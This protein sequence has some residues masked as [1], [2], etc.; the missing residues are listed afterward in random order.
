MTT[1]SN[2]LLLSAFAIAISMAPSGFGQSDVEV[3]HTKVAMR[4]IGHELL[5]STGDS[6]SR[7]LPVEEEPD[8][9]RISFDAE[10]EFVPD[11]LGATINRVISETHIASAYLVEVQ[12]CSTNEVV[13][14]YEVGVLPDKDLVACKGRLQ[15]LGCYSLFITVLKVDETQAALN[16]IT[17]DSHANQAKNSGKGIFAIGLV[18]LF[19][20]LYLF[21]KRREE[22]EADPNLIAIGAYQFDQ[23]NM[24]LLY[25]KEKSELTSK[26]ADLLFLLRS[27]AN[28]TVERDVILNNVWGDDGDYVGRTLDVF[29]SKL[30]KK[31]SSDSSVKIVNTRGVGYKL[32]L[33]ESKG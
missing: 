12:E 11:E 1:R 30:R 22:D 6:T 7:V 19:G 16:A 23:R 28:T 5:L 33:N 14:S 10:F 27:S 20:M 9:Y 32:V 3:S 4:L 8:G 2:F 17:P 25:G 13:Y 26:E 21:W 31:L 29:I 24:Q 18:M 15:P